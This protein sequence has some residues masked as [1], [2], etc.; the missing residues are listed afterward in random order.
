MFRLR[1]SPRIA[2][3][4]AGYQGHLFPFVQNKV[5]V[6]VVVVVVTVTSCRSTCISR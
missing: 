5:T 3:L 6:V 4:T 2:L 1:N